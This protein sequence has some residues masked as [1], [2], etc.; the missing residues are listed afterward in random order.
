M[1]IIL[2]WNCHKEQKDWVTL[3]E[4]SSTLHL[5]FLPWIS[6]KKVLYDLQHHPLI[7]ATLKMFHAMTRRFKLYTSPGSL[8]PVTHNPDLPPRLDLHLSSPSDQQVPLLITHCVDDGKLKPFTSLKQDL[9]CPNCFSYWTYRQVHNY[10]HTSLAKQQLT[11][12]TT[13]FEF[14]CLSGSQIYFLNVFLASGGQRYGDPWSTSTVGKSFCS[15][16][17]R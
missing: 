7:G 4:A 3:E 15:K 9:S 6:L 10:I 8:T 1:A 17:Y 13:P 2:D 5:R 11:R 16:P 12:H 14:V